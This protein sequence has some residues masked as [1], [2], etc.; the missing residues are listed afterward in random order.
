MHRP[1]KDTLF[2]RIADVARMHAYAL[3][4]ISFTV[5]ATINVAFVI[6]IG[7][8]PNADYVRMDPARAPVTS[9]RGS[10]GS[11]RLPH[12]G[13]VALSIPSGSTVLL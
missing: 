10:T 7:D 5:A 2:C 4:C 12:G 8:T 13:A 6:H 1:G 9:T 3:P 11:A